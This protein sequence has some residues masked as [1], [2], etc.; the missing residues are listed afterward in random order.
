MRENTYNILGPVLPNSN[1]NYA[2]HQEDNQP[3]PIGEWTENVKDATD[4]DR[5]ILGP[6]PLPEGLTSIINIT[7]MEEY[8][9]ATLPA[10]GGL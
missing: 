7:T 1:G 5:S 8:T 4:Y 6:T 10:L 2:W 9:L 3:I